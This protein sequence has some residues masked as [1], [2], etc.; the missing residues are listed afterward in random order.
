MSALVHTRI[1]STK[2]V[3]TSFTL[4]AQSLLQRRCACGGLA[5]HEGECAECQK[6]AEGN[7]QRKLVDGFGP[8]VGHDFSGVNSAA[9]ARL[10]VTPPGDAFEQE[11][12][13]VAEA[14]MSGRTGLVAASTRGPKIQREDSAPQTGPATEKP[15]SEAEKYKEAALK[16]SEALRATD[17][18]KKLEAQLIQQGKDFVSTT[19]GKAVA[20]TALAGALAA[21]IATNKELPMQIPE[22]PLDWLLPG[23]KAKLTWEG[24]VR[25]PTNVGLTV[26][27]GGGVSL[28]ASYS[29]APAAAGKPAEQKAALTVTIPLG[30]SS[31][32]SKGP[33]ESEKFQ[34]ETARL[35]AEKT[36]LEEANKTPQQRAQ[37]KQFVDDYVLSKSN[38]PLSPFA[39]PDL[40][41]KPRKRK[42][43]DESFM[44]MRRAVNASTPQA[45]PP[46]VDAVLTQSGTALDAWKRASAMI[47]AGCA[48]TRMR[49][50]RSRREPSRRQPTRWEIIWFLRRVPT[51]RPLSSGNV[52]WRTSWFIP[53][54]KARLDEPDRIKGFRRWRNR[55]C[56]DTLCRPASHAMRWWTG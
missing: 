46:M 9:P 14:V 30:D 56:S 37:E 19:E 18:G 47:S 32:K 24:P 12:D 44:L 51:S 54:N 23:L 41:L 16:L 4:P 17:E 5:G 36:K 39:P 49:R 55:S 11:A 45:A 10:T 50:R 15:K 8:G 38:D 53:F 2:P 22:I 26:T 42:K 3:T 48:F 29:D 43:P 20:G 28:G 21:L 35:Q 52:S 1:A 33:S 25:T 27:T 31:K 6:K 7:L 34:A 13:R 40:G